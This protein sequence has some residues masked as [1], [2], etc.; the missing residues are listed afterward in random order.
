MPGLG[1]IYTNI[2]NFDATI[3]AAQGIDWNADDVGYL[4]LDNK[5]VSPG[6][7][8]I[9]EIHLYT[10]D[11]DAEY[12]TGGVI[13]PEFYEFSDSTIY[14]NYVGAV[15]YLGTERGQY[16]VA[17]NVYRNLLGSQDIENLYL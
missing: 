3:G 11:V 14:I 13:P 8:A 7:N 5:L 15:L 2:E 6:D 9:I 4:A 16:K 12:I 1:D 17:V 10:T